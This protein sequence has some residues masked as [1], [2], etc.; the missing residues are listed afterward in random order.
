MLLVGLDPK[1]ERTVTIL[2]ALRGIEVVAF[3]TAE[4]ALDRGEGRL[5]VTALDLPKM[6]ALELAGRWRQGGSDRYTLLLTSI[7]PAFPRDAEGRFGVDRTVVRRGDW[8]ARVD[9]WMEQ[10]HAPNGAVPDYRVLAD[11]MIAGDVDTIARS[12]SAGD[13]AG[14]LEQLALTYVATFDADVALPVLERV[15]GARAALDE[16]ALDR[17][18]ALGRVGFGVVERIATADTAPPPLRGRAMRHLAATFEATMVAPIFEAAMRSEDNYVRFEGAHAALANAIRCGRFETLVG[19]AEGD[20]AVEVRTKAIAS[21]AREWPQKDVGPVLSRLVNTP[22]DDVR[23]VASQALVRIDAIE[24][25]TLEAAAQRGTFEERRAAMLS[26]AESLPWRSALPVLER[27]Q[28]DEDPRVRL[29]AFELALSIAPSGFEDSV[30]RAVADG[31][32]S[33]RAVLLGISKLGERAFHAYA[34]LAAHEHVDPAVREAA[35]RKLAVRFTER[36]ASI[37]G[38]SD[39]LYARMAIPNSRDVL[40]RGVVFHHADPSLRA[41]ALRVLDGH[42]DD[43]VVRDA[44]KRAARDDDE[45]VRTVAAEVAMRRAGAECAELLDQIAKETRSIQEGALDGA[46]ALGVAG[47]GGAGAI[48]Y[49]PRIDPA[50]R[51]RAIRWL[52]ETFDET[53][54]GPLFERIEAMRAGEIER[55]RH[56]EPEVPSAPAPVAADFWRAVTDG[57]KPASDTA[58]FWTA[59]TEPKPPAVDPADVA[60]TKPVPPALPPVDLVRSQPARPARPEPKPDGITLARA[61]EALQ[62]AIRA[63]PN[64]HRGLF[65]LAASDRVPESVR[66]QALRRLAADFPDRDDVP[67]LLARAM[68]SERTA[69]QAAA[70][71]AAMVRDD[72]SLDVIVHVAH[73]ASD[74][75]TRARATRFLGSKWPVREVR[76]ELERL[77]DS[78]R[79]EVRRAALGALFT[80]TRYVNESRLEQVLINLLENHEEIEVRASAARAL[81]AFGTKK[82]IRPLAKAGGAVDELRKPA[83]VAIKKIESAAHE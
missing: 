39:S 4:G 78:D 67:K 34:Y 52:A 58:T 14:R 19:L 40:L 43:A 36:A 48:A 72:T 7:P 1:T 51:H 66:V 80:T 45:H 44:S 16:I 24:L 29:V 68:R 3:R 2:A 30:A 32:A 8:L 18:I 50:V 75:A 35:L 55:A 6:G 47:F 69:L 28:V 79:N 65:V 81:G 73:E 63:G 64:G 17:A 74:A 77:L 56:G 41:E 57:S 10:R 46:I 54:R 60:D 53:D 25:D 20:V 42:G 21:L 33:Q 61:R 31:V 70:L 9:D 49:D 83:A 12:L 37:V 15:A 59:R 82:A 27:R 26:L 22:D 62:V 11:A 5:L 71:G 38:A 76:T 13:F 23:R